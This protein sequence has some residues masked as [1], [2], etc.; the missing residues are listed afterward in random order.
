MSD[1]KVYPIPCAGGFILNQN[2]E[3]LLIQSYKWKGLCIPAGKIEV[4]ETM[5]KTLKREIKEEVNLKIRDEKLM[6]VLDAIFPK[7]YIKKKHFIFHNFLC[8]TDNENDIKV[9]NDEI[10]AY[11]WVSFDRIL[12]ENLESY[13]RR[14]I[15]E[16]IIPYLK[17]KKK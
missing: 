9:D 16:Y 14:T 3:L 10:Q 12:S 15:E 5:V 2:N 6:C 1:Q 17:G 13:T 4:G 8:F 11:K 7:D